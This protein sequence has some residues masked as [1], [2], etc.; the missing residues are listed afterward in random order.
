[1]LS[2]R[3][4]GTLSFPFHGGTYVGSMVRGSAPWVS[5]SISSSSSSSSESD[6]FGSESVGSSP[7]LPLPPS[8]PSPPPPVL[9]SEPKIT[10]VSRSPYRKIEGSS[11]L[12]T[13]SGRP[14]SVART[15]SSTNDTTTPVG[16]VFGFLDA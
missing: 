4:L 14:S 9:E 12:S 7:P 6:G 5:S 1:M 3:S 8:L 13:T 10:R 11:P 2:S 16:V 15:T